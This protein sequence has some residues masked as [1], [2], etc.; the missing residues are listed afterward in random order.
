[1]ASGSGRNFR[2]SACCVAILSARAGWT[3]SRSSVE[4]KKLLLAAALS[5]A[6]LI[7]WEWIGPKP[8]RRPVS[9]PRPPAA[10]PVVS[11]EAVPPAPPAAEAISAE[12]ESLI[13][14]ENEVLRVTFS[15]RGALVTSLVLRMH[16]DDHGRP[17]EL[18][19]A[20]PSA[21]H[22]PLGLL[23]PGKEELTARVANAL[24]VIEKQGEKGARLRF[25]DGSV[26]VTKEISLS[27]GHLVNARISVEGP[28]YTLLAAAGLRNPSQKEKAS[29]YIPPTTAIATV[30]G[31]FERVRAD[32]IKGP[33][34]WP[35]PEGGFAGL[36]D[37][38]FLVVLA[39][40]APSA[41]RVLAVPAKDASGKETVTVAAGVSGSGALSARAYFGPKDV[42]ILEEL[43]MGL[44]RTVNFGWFSIVARPLL[45][46]LKKAYAWVGNYGVAILLVTFLIR[47]LLFPLTHKSYRSMKKMQK[48]APKMAVIRD[49]YK[50][51]KTDA[52]QRQKMN[53]ELMALYQAEG[54]NP[55]S[56]CFPILFQMPILFAFYYV[57]AN[58]IELRHAPFV[59]W[60]QDLSAVDRS[61]LLVILMTVTMYIQQA[62]MPSTVDPMQ[63]RIFLAMPLVMGFFM[64]EAPSGLVLYWFFSNVL[65]I[66]Q[67]LIINRMADKDKD[68]PKAEKPARLKKVRA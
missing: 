68:Q 50:K 47:L 43:G 7:L 33:E 49:K 26:G 15:N 16:T 18:V 51:A 34:S 5:L 22:R 46:L 17:L 62:M 48:L 21:A 40:G 35:L 39:P 1:M 20:L 61:Y 60:I 38:Y 14:L 10:T 42:E 32:K 53:Q 52:A 66:L 6:V 12:R 44:E 58:A 37:N 36:E 63:K 9:P 57:L 29:T 28:P 2:S 3:R 59:L 4:G 56:G 27:E 13:V 19:R 67:Q 30:G 31:G 11:P 55:M 23:F 24:F 65:T 8:A 54:Y 25:S 45:W 64:K 41:A